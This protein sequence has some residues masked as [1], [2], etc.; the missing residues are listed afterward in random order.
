MPEAVSLKSDW[1]TVAF[2]DVVKKVTDKV[3]PEESGLERYVAGEHMDTDD[4]RIRRW[5]E[6]GD[7]YL[8]PAFHM[9]FK[10]GQVLYGSRRTYLR[11]VAL[12]D[13][14]GITAN[15]TYVLESK[16]PEIL[17]PELLPFLMQAETFHEHS[18]RESR[19]SV[20]PYV[21]F[22]D[23]AWYEFALP[24]LKEQR[25]IVEVLTSLR[26]AS[27]S[28]VLLKN[29]AT[30]I[31]RVSLSAALKLETTRVPE[32][33]TV[34]AGWDIAK[35][36]EL[37]DP[38]RPVS[39]GI[40]KPGDE[41]PSGVPMLRVQ[42]FDDYGA[43]SQTT[44]SKVSRE[45]ADTSKT[46]YLEHGDVVVSI[47]ATIGRAMLVTP[48]MSGWNVNRALAVLP[49]GPSVEGDF[50]EAYL[51]SSFVQRIFFISQIGGVQSRINLEFLKSLLVPVPPKEIRM[52]TVRLR[53]QLGANLEEIRQRRDVIRS[54][55]NRFLEGL[56]K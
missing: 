44:I 32:L 41:D 28:L 20:N 25:G 33:K 10:P 11:K 5:G 55:Q 43:R 48:S 39:Y 6:I 40:L 34:P 47:M 16:D 21:N 31:F 30:R 22:S 26:K 12:A 42:D 38:D 15:T 14:E 50:L 37:T 51:Q 36:S 53:N 9:R 56:S 18:K 27:D 13:F 24:P 46:T 4:L 52:K 23:L 2:G 54:M 7:D 29:Q 1:T 3:D 49:A 19:G 45:I 35:L 17:L 8:G